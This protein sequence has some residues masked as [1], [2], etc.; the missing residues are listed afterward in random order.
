MK[1]TVLGR[2][3][4]LSE[5]AKVIQRETHMLEEKK[6]SLE[7]SAKVNMMEGNETLVKGKKKAQSLRSCKFCGK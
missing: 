6:I 2:K 1:I 5:E 3:L 7:E 4:Q